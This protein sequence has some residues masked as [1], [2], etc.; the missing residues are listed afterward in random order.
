[1]IIIFCG[2]DRCG[3]DTQIRNA[4]QY[5]LEQNENKTVHVLHYSALPI[6]DNIKERSSLLYCDMFRIADTFRKIDDM[7]LIFNRAH[8]GETVYSPLYRNYSGDFVFDI[9]KY[10]KDLMKEIRLITL[11]D[12]SFKCLTE[13]DDGLSLSAGSIEKA[14]KEVEGFIR[15]TEMSNIKH[16]IIIDIANST[17]EEVKQK[18][19]EFL[20][21]ENK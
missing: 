13:R 14:N 16:K 19:I 3:K 10:F 8:L 6:T 1:M 15:A 2:P 20:S 21:D 4:M 5:L 7:H 9:E 11:I 18:V 12:S 17:V